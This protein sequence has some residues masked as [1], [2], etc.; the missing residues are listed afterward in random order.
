MKYKKSQLVK[1]STSD[2]VYWIV[3]VDDNI[4]EVEDAWGETYDDFCDDDLT[5]LTIHDDLRFRLRAVNH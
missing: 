1:S 2:N 4:Y 3:G 5:A